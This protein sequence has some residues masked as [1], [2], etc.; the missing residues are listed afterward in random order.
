MRAVDGTIVVNASTA[1]SPTGT[2]GT[3]G[4][5]KPLSPTLGATLVIENATGTDFSAGDFHVKNGA[6]WMLIYNGT[7]WNR[8]EFPLDAGSQK[9]TNVLAGT[10]ATDGVNVSQLSGSGATILEPMFVSQ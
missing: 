10:A 4:V 9:I 3:T 5:L 8:V 7:T 1:Q 6:R 2:A